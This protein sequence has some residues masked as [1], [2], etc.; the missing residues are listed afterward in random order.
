MID[1]CPAQSQM[2]TEKVC[3]HNSSTVSIVA[4]GD[5]IFQNGELLVMFETKQ[6]H[7]P[8]IDK[9]VTFLENSVYIETG[10]KY[11]C[12]YGKYC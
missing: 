4:T 5:R 12:L 11:F 2:Q 8:A 3:F 10:Q 7:L 1:T 6:Y 9:I